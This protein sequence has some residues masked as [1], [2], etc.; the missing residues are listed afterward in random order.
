MD[1]Y[2]VCSRF[3]DVLAYL[4]NETGSSRVSF[5][6]LVKVLS[7]SSVTYVHRFSIHLFVFSLMP[8]IAPY[9]RVYYLSSLDFMSTQAE[10]ILITLLSSHAA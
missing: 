5:S 3:C 8:F 10:F 9:L 4:S 1:T 7:E 2:V 6:S